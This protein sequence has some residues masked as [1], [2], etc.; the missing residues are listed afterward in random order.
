M[1]ATIFGPPVTVRYKSSDS[2]R[3]IA[4]LRR[5]RM[6][7]TPAVI[8]FTGLPKHM[9]EREA[10]QLATELGK[11]FQAVDL[12]ALS[13]RYIG[14]TEKHLDQLL[15]AAE[16]SGVVLFFDEADALFGERTTVKDAHDRYANLETDYLLQRLEQH[17][18]IAILA[19]N[20][21]IAA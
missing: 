18:G 11:R 2:A 9:L 21:P 16:V 19:V 20:T 15:R 8:A 17:R 6:A 3:L 7:T 10:R 13:S 12:K 1:D 4:T 14:E 5:E